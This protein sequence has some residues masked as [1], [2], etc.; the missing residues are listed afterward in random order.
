MLVGHLA[1]VVAALFSGAAVYINFAEQPARLKLDD[2]ALLA[3]WKPSY[4]RGFIMQA[5]LAVVG[6]LLGL[7]AWWTTGR[8][9]FAIGGLLMI[10]N[11]PWTVFV[12]MPTN[13]ILMQTELSA[14]GPRSRALIIKWNALHAV[15]SG[16]GLLAT[17][18][19]LIALSN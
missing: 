7:A 4:K 16:F 17:L 8:L 1:L 3:Q 14:S 6:C 11:L 10:A 2:Q 15:R 13:K 19:F 5:P 12:I 9:A 18:A